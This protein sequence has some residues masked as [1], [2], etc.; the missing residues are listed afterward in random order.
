MKYKTFL[1]VSLCQFN[2]THHTFCQFSYTLNTFLA[3]IYS[4]A[5]CPLQRDY[6]S[7]SH[8][9]TWKDHRFTIHFALFKIDFKLSHRCYT[10]NI[11]MVSQR[12]H[13]NLK[14]TVLQSQ[15]VVWKWWIFRWARIRYSERLMQWK[16]EKTHINWNS[17]ILRCNRSYLRTLTQKF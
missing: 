15:S 10:L 14:S 16:W 8:R 7:G 3:Y 6:H 11:H 5:F 13:F 1:L 9:T 2:V 17:R 12:T 4:S